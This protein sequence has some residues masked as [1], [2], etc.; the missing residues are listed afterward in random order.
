ML[1]CVVTAVSNGGV[2]GDSCVWRQLWGLE[3]IRGRQAS[4]RRDGG[5]LPTKG[6]C[7]QALVLKAR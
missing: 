5:C 3:A 4:P 6:H 2:Y 1:V 7:G